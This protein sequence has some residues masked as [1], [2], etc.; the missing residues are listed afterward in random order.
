MEQA[1]SNSTPKLQDPTSHTKTFR[2]SGITFEPNKQLYVDMIFRVLQQPSD[3]ILELEP[4]ASSASP[5]LR[6]R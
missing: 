2:K 1:H 4:F 6:P 5:D 3:T